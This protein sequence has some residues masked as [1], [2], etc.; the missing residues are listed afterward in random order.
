MSNVNIIDRL[1][2]AEQTACSTCTLAPGTWWAPAHKLPT[3][4]Y[5]DALH[6]I[7]LA[8]MPADLDV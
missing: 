8:L 3:L 5:Q 7:S 2:L 1:A 4:Q 6:L